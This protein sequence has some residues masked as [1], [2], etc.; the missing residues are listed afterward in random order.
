M[1]KDYWIKKLDME[2]HIEGGYVKAVYESNYK[3][4]VPE[5]RSICTSIYFLITDKSFS[6]FH[7]LKSDEIWYFHAGKALSLTIITPNGELQEW[8]LGLDLDNGERP[9]V[10]VPAGSIFAAHIPES[11]GYTLVSCMVSYGFDYQD[12]K[13][14]KK[15]ELI[16]LFPKYRDIIEKLAT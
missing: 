16:E 5:E 7:S 11:K 4:N 9:H 13:L 2:E 8:K 10:L 3:I 6:H 12:F 1:N 14:Y 15:G